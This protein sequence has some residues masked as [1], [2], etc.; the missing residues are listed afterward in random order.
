VISIRQYIAERW[1]VTIKNVTDGKGVN[2]REAVGWYDQDTVYLPI[3]RITE[4][5]GGALKEQRTAAVLDQGGYLTRR[6]GPKRIAIRYVPRVGY[7]DCYALRRSKF[8]RTDKDTDPDELRVVAR[9][10]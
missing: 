2:N 8:G 10:G 3:N 9:D 4:A 7:V 1:D 5:A 6:G